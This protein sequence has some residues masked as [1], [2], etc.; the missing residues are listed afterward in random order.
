MLIKGIN[1]IHLSGALTRLLKK[2]VPLRSQLFII[3]QKRTYRIHKTLQKD[4]EIPCL[5]CV[6]GHKK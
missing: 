1:S 2:Y 6:M 5:G 3:A 4:L